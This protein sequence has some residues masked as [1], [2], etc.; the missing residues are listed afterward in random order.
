MG[1]IMSVNETDFGQGYREGDEARTGRPVTHD[2]HVSGGF[3]NLGETLPFADEVAPVVSGSK[4][5][6]SSTFVAA[7]DHA[8]NFQTG[9]S[10]GVPVSANFQEVLIG[11]LV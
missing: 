8:H 11:T 7:A 9:V 3:H 1:E 5:L 6:G 4:I 2:E 10:S